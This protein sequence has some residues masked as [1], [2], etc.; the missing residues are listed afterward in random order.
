MTRS[1]IK[2]LETLAGL[3]RDHDMARLQRLASARDATRDRVAQ[4]SAPVAL[5]DDPALFAARQAHLAW[6]AAQ[7]MQLNVALAR[8]TADLLDQRRKALRS[9]G[10]AQALARL[11]ARQGR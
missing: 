7:R 1:R 6:A 9:F 4:L 11:Q 8:Q 3:I 5:C 2:A 10:R